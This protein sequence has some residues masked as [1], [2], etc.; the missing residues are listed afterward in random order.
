MR[1]FLITVLACASLVC[2]S[3]AHAETEDTI[4][5]TLPA[6]TATHLKLDAD[7]GSISVQSGTGQ[8]VNME[9]F[10]RGD[11]PDRAE[12]NRM[13][14]DFRL[15]V[16]QQG[17]E[18]RVNGIFV[19][20]WEPAISFVIDNM[21]SG[22]SSICRNWQCLTYSRWLRGIDY[23]ISVPKQFSADLST[24]GGP[25]AVSDLKGDV[26][27]HTSGG[28]IT[29]NGTQGRVIAHTSG[30]P[31]RMTDIGG[32]VDAST[33]GG[34]IS[35][36]GA[37]GHVK[38][39]TSGGPINAMEIGGTIDASTSGGGVTASLSGQPKG[40]CRLTSSGGPITVKLPGDSRVT[41]EASTSG[42]SVSTDF[43]VQYAG[44]RHRS[45]LHTVLN[46]GG[47]LVYVHTSGGGVR[48]LQT[49]SL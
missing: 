30:G 32:D 36:E 40:E 2:A 39:H 1:P 15:D 3:P 44:E 19:H 48:I 33:S 11:P 20:G 47:P 28:S 12:F 22:G 42:G 23:R 9:V 37:S 35:I 7:F 45:E 31:I 27:A 25:I 10:F 21:F 29:L 46:G 18:I 16:S 26:T 4:R 8:T 41:L 49:G 34:G 14:H 5:K 6:S 24:S 13:L 17:S 43:P 38:A